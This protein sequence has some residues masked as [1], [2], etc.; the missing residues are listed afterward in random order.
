MANVH[1]R[2]IFQSVFEERSTKTV[3]Y[4]AIDKLQTLNTQLPKNTCQYWKE[5]TDEKLYFSPALK[6]EGWKPTRKVKYK[7]KYAES[8]RLANKFEPYNLTS[9][10]VEQVQELRLW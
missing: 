9:P 1:S 3:I 10:K 8:V 2:Y 7:L 4:C 6:R 5:Q